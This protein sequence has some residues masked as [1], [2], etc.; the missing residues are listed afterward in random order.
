MTDPG[1]EQHRTDPAGPGVEYHEVDEPLHE[2]DQRQ[3]HPR[4]HQVPAARFGAVDSCH[5]RQHPGADGG[6]QADRH[7]PGRAEPAEPGKRGRQGCDPVG[8]GDARILGSATPFDN[9]T[10]PAAGHRRARLL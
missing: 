8:G 4:R 1:V 2:G 3:H 6:D 9:G 7:G 10:G 5:R